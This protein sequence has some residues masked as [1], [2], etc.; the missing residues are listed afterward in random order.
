[1]NVVDVRSIAAE[2]C[3]CREFEVDDNFYS[4]TPPSGLCAP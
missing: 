4:P 3:F 2:R 1:M